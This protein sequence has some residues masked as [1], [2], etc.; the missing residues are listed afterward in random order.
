MAVSWKGS[1]AFGLI[2]IPVSLYIATKEESIGFNML[3]K[4]CLTRIRYKKVCEYCDVEVKS[5]EIVK[6]YNYDGDKYVVFT[7]DDFEKIKTP[8][9]KSIN[10]M[11][12]VDLSEIDPVFYEKAYYIVPNGGEKAFELLKQALMETNKV[13][14]A[15]VVFGTK[16]TLVALRVANKRM[17]LNTLYFVNEIKS[18]EVP[19]Q[20]VEINPLEVNLAKQLIMQMSKPFQPDIYH[21]EYQERLKQ[22]FEQKI[23]GE[24]ISVPKEK[25]DKNII[26]L[27]DAL[28]KSIAQ[29]E[30]PRL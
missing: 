18:V 6:G 16:E 27:M 19:Y 5:D 8:K 9:D 15:K 24:E 4:E 29:L 25:E 26:N 14:I 20:N 17:L 3:H 10:I 30:Q 28:Q 7:D 1:I 13:G 12:F 2:Y 21:D 11:Q 22:A 23:L